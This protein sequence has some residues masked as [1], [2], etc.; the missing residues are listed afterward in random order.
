MRTYFP[1]GNDIAGIERKWYLIN[2]EG[3]IL[4]RLATF[5]ANI[6]SGKNKPEYTPYI[7]M[8]DHVIIINA[9]KVV[10]TGKKMDDKIYYHS[11]GYLGHLKAYTVRQV[12]S[13][14]PD[15]IVLKAVKGMLPKTKLGA[16]MF[17]KIKVYASAEHRHKAQKPIPLEVPA[18]RRFDRGIKEA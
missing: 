4:G 3:V 16:K 12:L 8:G 18:E 1:K 9:D 17:G 6:L 14:H 7:D 2:A 11:T 10:L 5:V 13:K 15:R